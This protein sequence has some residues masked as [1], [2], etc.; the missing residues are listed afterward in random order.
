MRILLAGTPTIALPIFDAIASSDIEVAGVITNPPKARGRSG[1]AVHSPI[2]KWAQEKSLRVFESGNFE[3][4]RSELATIDLVLVVAYGRLIPRDLLTIPKFGW[5]NIHFS[6]LPEARGAA[7]VQRLIEMGR[8]EI[9]YTLFRLDD[10]MDTGPIFHLS[11]P[12]NIKDL[13]TGEVWDVLAGK[14]AS[15]IVSLLKEIFAGKSPTK[16]PNYDG[17]LPLAPKITVEEARLDWSQRNN[18]IVQK[19]RAFNPAPS[20]WTLFQGERFIIHNAEVAGEDDITFISN[21]PGEI[22][23][24]KDDVFVFA[25][26]GVVRCLEVQPFGKKPMRA[27]DWA[28][29]AH[30][31]PG[32]RFE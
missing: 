9:G 6:H 4:F 25:G 5:I 7:P 17:K 15:E 27:P 14:A 23:H 2:S 28:R 3:E 11:E 13:T 12:L 10:G 8:E 26:S 16:Q 1:L 20:A 32:L 19:I 31:E 21:K 24:N 18:D 22:F 30:L 29:G